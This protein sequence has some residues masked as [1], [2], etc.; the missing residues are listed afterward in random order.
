MALH[1]PPIE[2]SGRYRG[3]T[4]FSMGRC[5]QVGSPTGARMAHPGREQSAVLDCARL[6]PHRPLAFSGSGDLPDDLGQSLGEE[7]WA[8][9]SESSHRVFS[10]AHRR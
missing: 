2:A 8:V 5:D 3:N 7:T 1:C 4:R 9:R 10:H 6:R